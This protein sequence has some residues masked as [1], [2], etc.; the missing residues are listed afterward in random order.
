MATV[1][2]EDGDILIKTEPVTFQVL[3]VAGG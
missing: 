3:R 2:D 1:I